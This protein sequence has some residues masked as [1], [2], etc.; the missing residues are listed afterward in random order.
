M[1]RHRAQQ[2]AL[3][4]AA[5]AEDADA[6]AFAARQQAIDGAHA[7]HQ[8]LDDV[9]TL[10]RIARPA[11]QRI[12]VRGGNRRSAIDGLAETVDHPAQQAR[13][14]LDPRLLAAGRHRI[15]HFESVDFFQRHRKHAPVAKADHLG[16]D[17]PPAGCPH[18]AK[19]ADGRRR[20][21]RFNGQPDHFRHLARPAQRRDA[22]Q[23]VKTRR[24]RDSLRHDCLSQAVGQAAL[25]LFQLR[26]HRSIQIAAFGFE[27]ERA[28]LP[29]RIRHHFHRLARRGLLQQRTHLRRHGR[30]HSDAMNLLGVHFLQGCQRQPVEG[31]RIHRQFAPQHAPGH[32]QRQPQH[33]VFGFPPQ[34]GPQE[35]EFLNAPRQPV[36]YRLNLGGGLLPP[37]GFTFPKGGR[38]GLLDGLPPLALHLRQTLCRARWFGTGGSGPAAAY[39]PPGARRS[40]P[41]FPVP[42]P[43]HPRRHTARPR[44]PSGSAH[45]RLPVRAPRR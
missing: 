40:A 35:G 43:Q 21:A 32:R 45:P 17:A 41:R 8:R 14:Y 25:D 11:A 33:V 3:A 6:L 39:R 12:S 9:L 16:A 34:P 38:P 2:R 37:G 7:R 22:V 15:A 19:I 36:D 13:T 5:A 18:F 1:A 4:H 44:L 31:F 27:N 23:L 24:Q 28:R 26:L 20:T 10:Q 42:R 30:V 29:G